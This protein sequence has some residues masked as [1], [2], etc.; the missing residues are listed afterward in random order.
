MINSEDSREG[1]RAA[2]KS[3]PKLRA[4]IKKAGKLSSR[5]HPLISRLESRDHRRRQR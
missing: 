5:Q 4:L 1:L 2:L 3:T